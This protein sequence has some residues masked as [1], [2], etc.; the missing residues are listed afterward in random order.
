MEIHTDKIYFCSISIYIFVQI[1][2]LH[3]IKWLE[4]ILHFTRL[5]TVKEDKKIT[6]P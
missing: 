3:Q 5:R 2:A 6:L 4:N 1:V